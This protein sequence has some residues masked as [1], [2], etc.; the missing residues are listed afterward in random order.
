MVASEVRTLAQRSAN[1][2]KDIKSLISDSVNKINNGNELVGK[3]GNTMKEIVTSIKRVNDIMSE[4]AAASAEQ[5]AG[6]DEVGKAVTQMDEMTQQNAALVEEAAAAAKDCPP[7]PH[8]PFGAATLVT[9]VGTPDSFF[10]FGTEFEA[11]AEALDFCPR[12]PPR[13]LSL[14]RSPYRPLP[15]ALPPR[16]SL[17][18]P[19]LPPPPWED[20]SPLLSVLPLPDAPPLSLLR[21]PLTRSPPPLPRDEDFSGTFLLTLPTASH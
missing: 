2:A 13:F 5:S 4:I 1:A 12:S 8:A 6:L 7:D 3:S 19:S 17:R 18:G 16:P 20:L 9:G 11:E 21:E 10:F 14:S 15:P